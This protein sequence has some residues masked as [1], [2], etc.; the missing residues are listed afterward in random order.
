MKDAIRIQLTEIRSKTKES[1]EWYKINRPDLLNKVHKNNFHS[2]KPESVALERI[3]TKQKIIDYVAFKT[4]NK[5]KWIVSTV[6]KAKNMYHRSYKPLCIIE[7]VP[8]KSEERDYKCI[9]FV[10]KRIKYYNW[11]IHD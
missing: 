6:C 3:C 4:G 1:F 9:D 2:L 8:D 7:L 10:N 11:F 5:G